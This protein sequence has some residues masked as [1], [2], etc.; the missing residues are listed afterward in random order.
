MT[1]RPVTSPPVNDTRSTPPCSL[2]GAPAS[3]PAPSTR[4]PTPA[5]SPASTRYR[6][7]RIVVLGRE[8]AG[9]DDERVPGGEGRCHLPR[10]LQERV[11]PR[12]DEAA[13]ADRLVGDARQDRRI[14]RLDQPPGEALRRTGEVA[15]ALHHVG[16]VVAG[17]DDAL[18][19]VEGLRSRHR[20]GLAL[21]DVGG[22]AEQRRALRRGRVPPR[23]LVER[24]SRGL[25]GRHGVLG[26]GLVDDRHQ[27]AVRGTPDLAGAALGC[28]HPA[29]IDQQVCQRACPRSVSRFPDDLLAATR[30][31][32]GH[33]DDRTKPARA[34]ADWHQ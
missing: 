32:A 26:P 21:E 20:L 23:A 17:L 27:G 11:V 9:L 5:G 10:G 8:L 7:S 28:G 1:R 16:D 14:A 29:A 15:E 22:P 24:A 30:S 13:D 3:G 25:D 31:P 2:S 4:L 19:G 18:P 33:G 34:A 6:M 12:G